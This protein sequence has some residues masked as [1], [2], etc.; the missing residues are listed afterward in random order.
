MTRRAWELCKRGRGKQG[1]KQTR[2]RVHER[3]GASKSTL[4]INPVAHTLLFPKH[5]HHVLFL[6]FLLLRLW[7]EHTHLPA[8]FLSHMYMLSYFLLCYAF[9][10][11]IFCLSHTTCSFSVCFFGH[12]CSSHL[13]PSFYTHPFS[14]SIHPVVFLHFSSLY[15]TPFSPARSSPCVQFSCPSRLFSFPPT[16]SSLVPP[17]PLFQHIMR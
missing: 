2:S 15:L 12:L 10:I 9:Y 14:P 3:P 5:S 16:F 7:C 8:S 6:L 1:S 4:T 13:L 17:L 11:Y